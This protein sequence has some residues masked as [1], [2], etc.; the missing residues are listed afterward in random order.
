MDSVVENR[1]S[2]PLHG[3]MNARNING[4][5]TEQPLWFWQDSVFTQASGSLCDQK[6]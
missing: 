4:F 6:E 2:G 3:H 5:I 1:E